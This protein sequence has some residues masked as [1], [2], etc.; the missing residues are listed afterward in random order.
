LP[1]ILTNVRLAP[2]SKASLERGGRYRVI[3]SNRA[4]SADYATAEILLLERPRAWLSEEKVASMPRLRLIQTI[5]AGLDDVDFAVIPPKVTV[6]GN[7]GAYAD[8]MAEYVFG[9]VISLGRGF[10]VDHESLRKGVFHRNVDGISLRGKTMG[11][12]GAGGIGRSVARAARGFGMRTIGMNT[13]GRSVPNFDAMVG[14]G[15]LGRV[16]KESD[17]LVVALPLTRRTENLLDAGKLRL[18]KED[19]VLVNVGRAKVID[20]RALFE[21][22]K[23]NPSFRA[24]SDVWWVYPKQDE[25]FA[26][27]YP[28]FDLPNF[29]GTPHIS[30]NVV[31]ATLVAQ[32]YAARNIRRFIDGR[33]VRGA[34]D[35][36]EY[37]RDR[38]SASPPTE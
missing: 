14:Q 10:A 3:E 12:L 32:S 7:V 4:S 2:E 37:Q 33:A 34:A 18:M 28:F 29:M 15:G 9:V 38:P 23:A 21:R 36:R 35:R 6:C 30:G 17:V 20:E 11:V 13:D 1:T 27:H 25:R 16:L 8:A 22:L 5:F 24:A 19:S 26:Q 31:G